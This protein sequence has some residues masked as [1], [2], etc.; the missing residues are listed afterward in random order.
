MFTVLVCS[1]HGCLPLNVLQ[2][3]RDITFSNDGRRFV[4]TGFDKMIRVW[5]TETGA[6]LRSLSNG[7]MNYCVTLHPEK[8]VGQT[9]MG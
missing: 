9:S 1:Y 8:Q 2:G 5:D 6:V 3:V 4:S 7:K